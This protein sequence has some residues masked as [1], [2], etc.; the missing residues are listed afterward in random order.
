MKQSRWE[1]FKENVLVISVDKL[2]V[3]I[4]SVQQVIVD[5]IDADGIATCRTRAD[6]PEID[7]CLFIYEGTKALSVGDIVSVAVE[8]AADYDLWGRLM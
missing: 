4:G 2:T 8:E 7:G 6:A 5:D 3:K 1:R